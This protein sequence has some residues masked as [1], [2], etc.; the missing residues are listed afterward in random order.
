M[1][2][3]A[4]IVAAIALVAGCGKGDGKRVRRNRDGGVRTVT[5]DPTGT[6]RASAG[7][8]KE[9]NGV[10]TE[11]TPLPPGHFVRGSLDG[12]ADVDVYRVAVAGAG[13]LR[14][15]LTG[16]DGVDLVLEL[17]DAAGAVLAKSDRGPAMISEGMPG[18]GVGKGEY[19]LVVREFVKK[20]PA[21][22]KKKG[23]GAGADAAPQGRVGPSNVYELSVEVLPAAPDLHEIEPND[24]PGT[25]VEVLLA[26]SVKGWVGWNGDVDLWKLSLEGVAAQYCLDID[27]AG[28][29]GAALS[30]EVL[31]AGG[32]RLLSRKG[33]KG[34]PVVI[35]SVVPAL[36]DAAPPWHFVKISADRSNPEATYELRF[37][38][39]L[40]EDDEEREP[41]DTPELASP[42]VG[43]GAVRA[44][45]SSG[46]V[47]RFR[48]DAQ[49]EPQLLDVAVEP[50][51]GIDL[52][53]AV[54]IAGQPPL[55]TANA[56]AAGARESL[57]AV[58]LPARAPVVVTVS[59][60]T[61]KKADPGGEA[62]PYRLTWSLV[63]AAGDPMPPEE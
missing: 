17:R 30:V 22:K 56:G 6:G 33:D 40:L 14:A 2:P 48:I 61:S 45:Y 36:A 27:V 11:A 59:A 9:P 5:P 54:G 62:R 43:P 24:D 7:E 3:G 25:A 15:A 18:Y 4:W 51:P 20:K 16:I 12:E 49:T 53:L 37:T 26:D 32:E 35:K 34:G 55:A 58:A 29:D 39:R 47:D 63:P 1:R 52:E 8:E 19:F 38:A 41:N 10:E 60:K 13:Q 28:V 42:M 23:T 46:D 21:A 31:D 50:P 57:A 44:T